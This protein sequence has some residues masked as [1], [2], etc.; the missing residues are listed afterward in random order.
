MDSDLD[1]IRQLDGAQ[2][3]ER[4]KALMLEC[5]YWQHVLDDC[6][7]VNDAVLAGT[8]AVVEAKVAAIALLLLADPP[9]V[10]LVGTI[11]AQQRKALESLRAIVDGL[12]GMIKLAAGRQ[13]ALEPVAL[14]L[15]RAAGL[16]PDDDDQIGEQ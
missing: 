5:E 11:I 16:E 4:A 6:A 10:E 8:N 14:E 3:A 12:D 1:T 7:K 15:R 13:K 2:V 9:M